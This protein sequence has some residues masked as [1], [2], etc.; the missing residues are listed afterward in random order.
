MPKIRGWKNISK[1]YSDG[2]KS[3]EWKSK[4][5]KVSVWN[6]FGWRWSVKPLGNNLTPDIVEGALNTKEI[7]VR[8]AMNYMRRHPNG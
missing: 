4:T 6:Y 7:A 1:T 3:L 2:S 5:S 8:K